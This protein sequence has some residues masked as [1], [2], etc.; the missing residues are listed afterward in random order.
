MT[1]ESVISVKLGKKVS[2]LSI[3]SPSCLCCLMSQQTE[4]RAPDYSVHHFLKGLPFPS[5]V[6]ITL[7]QDFFSSRLE[8][9]ACLKQWNET[10]L[11]FGFGDHKPDFLALAVQIYLGKRIPQ[12]AVG[13]S[14]HIEGCSFCISHLSIFGLFK[15]I[16]PDVGLDSTRQ[17]YKSVSGKT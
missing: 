8:R 15:L 14:Q 4:S 17:M 3:A 7:V 1:L 2:L 10:Y 13:E 6:L 16:K 12:E 11:N 5:T 9:I